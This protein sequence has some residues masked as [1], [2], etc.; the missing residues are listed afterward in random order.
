M[1]SLTVSCRRS[2]NSLMSYLEPVLG[3]FFPPSGWDFVDGAHSERPSR[4]LE[5]GRRKINSSLSSPMALSVW[6]QGMKEE[7]RE[8]ERKEK[9]IIWRRAEKRRKRDNWAQCAGTFAKVNEPISPKYIPR[10]NSSSSFHPT[11]CHLSPNA[12]AEKQFLFCSQ[13]TSMD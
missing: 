11:R 7:E 13:D 10:C 3:G 8:N 4:D 9:M 5:S 2:L 6:F 1:L 12:L